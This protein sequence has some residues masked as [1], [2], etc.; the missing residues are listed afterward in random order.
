[1]TKEYKYLAGG[2]WKKSSDV[3]EVRNPF[4]DSIPFTT[5]KATGDDVEMATKAAVDAFEQ[6]KRLS[7]YEKSEVLTN[8]WKGIEKRKREIAEIITLESGK[9]LQYSLI[10][11]ERSVFLFQ[12]ASEEAKRIKGETIPLDLIKA[13]GDTFA[14]NKHFPIGPIFG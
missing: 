9:P 13:T 4:D 2:E 14:I 12:I 3:L 7:S 6:T 11:V 1:M 5:Y 8:I 10:E